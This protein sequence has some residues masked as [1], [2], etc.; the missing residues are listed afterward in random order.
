M[1]PR[2]KVCIG[3]VYAKKFPKEK[4][5]QLLTSKPKPFDRLQMIKARLINYSKQS[6]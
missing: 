1:L 5:K 4:L 3:R 6:E 2:R